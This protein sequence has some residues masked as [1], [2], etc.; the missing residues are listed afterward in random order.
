MERKIALALSGGG[1]RAIAFHLGCLR[2]LKRHRILDDIKTVSS[3]SGGSVIA[4]AYF[5][6]GEDFD[7][8]EAKMVAL[9]KSGLFSP[10]LRTLFSHWGVM[11][12]ISEIVV[13]CLSLLNWVLAIIPK[14][15]RFVAK[16]F[17]VEIWNDQTFKWGL[18]RYFSRTS[19][20][21]KTLDRLLFDGDTIDMLAKPEQKLILN[22]TEL[23][24]GSAFR[25]STDTS[26]GWRFG[27][28]KNQ[29]IAV[30]HAVAAS[31]A[32]PLFLTHFQDRY[33]FTRK[34]GTKY[35]NTVSLTDGGIYDN[36][37]LGP[38]WPE[39]SEDV[40][41]NVDPSKIIICCSAG[42]GLRSDA[43]PLYWVGRMMQSFYTTFDRAQNAAI[44]KMT[45][46]KQDGKIDLLIFPYL[47][48]RDEKLPDKPVDL[49][50]REEVHTYPTDFFGMSDEKILRIGQRGEQLTDHLLKLYGGEIT[51]T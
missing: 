35:F 51:N 12:L 14:T 33:E 43:H 16:K 9:L 18:R 30:A 45:K 34:D 20:L 29:K 42:Y 27:E 19:L 31:A 26:G 41:Y 47:G 48:M 44:D 46:L 15:I 24:T 49:V 38:L 3:V 21:E 23:T 8:F 37:G 32:Y 4:A 40:S 50:S 36:L 6:H 22:S 17:G 39:R 1:S 13:F 5:K 11:W 10:T 7:E 25:F 28:L 2:S